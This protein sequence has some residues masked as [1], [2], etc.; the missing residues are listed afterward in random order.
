MQSNNNYKP[1]NQDSSVNLRDA[2][3]FVWR[4]RWIIAASAVLALVVAFAYLRMQ[5][6][7]Y[8]RSTWI[9]LNKND[10]SNIDMNLMSTFSGGRYSKRVDNEATVIKSPSMMCAVV[11]ELG[12]NRRYYHYCM[13]IADRARKGRRLFDVKRVEYYRDN[14]FEMVESADSLF[15]KEF[16]PNSINLTFD[17]VDG[18][19]FQV[20]E[21]IVNGNKIEDF[22]AKE[23]LQYGKEYPIP[24]GH[25]ALNI[26]YPEQM[27]DGDRYVATLSSPW[28]MALS[29]VSKLEITTQPSF[30]RGDNTDVVVAS[31]TDNSQRRADDVLNAL[32]LEVN[33]AGKDYA[34]T[35]AYNTI[36]FLDER[37]ASIAEN[38]NEAEL[39]YQQYQSNNVAIDLASQS[40]LSMSSDMNYQNQLV[41]V[42]TQIKILDMI[43][44]YLHQ[45][46]PGSYKVIP[47][48]IGISDGG[49]NSVISTYNSLVAERNR[50]LANASENNPRVVNLSAQLDESKRGIEVSISNLYKVYR[51][52]ENELSSTLASSKRKMSSLPTQRLQIQQLSRKVSVIEP[53]YMLLQQKREEAQISM[54]SQ[55]ETFRIIEKSYGSSSPVSPL[56]MRVYLLA[57]LI[58]VCVP[59]AFVLLRTTLRSKVETKEDIK[60]ELGLDVLVMI[61]QAKDADNSL[62]FARG[63]DAS[64]ESFRMLRSSLQYMPGSKI[65][66]VTSSIPGEGKSFVS[67]NLAISLAIAGKKVLLIGMDLRKPALH[68]IFGV[69]NPGQHSLVSYMIGKIA[70]PEEAVTHSTEYPGL[71]LVFAGP[72]P[73][74]PSELLNA[75]SQEEFVKALAPAYDYVLIDSAPLL[76]VTDSTIINKMVDET[77]VVVRAGYTDLRLLAELNEALENEHGSIKNPK[78][79][80]NG[81]DYSLVKYHY[82]Y[83][84]SYSYGYGY[85]SSRAKYGYGYGRKYGYGISYRYGGNFDYGYE[86]DEKEEQD[87][88]KIA[89]DKKPGGKTEGG[90]A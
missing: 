87:A 52:R 79:I 84:R 72:V 40:Q 5:T 60:N 50:L 86:S 24:G 49:L 3:D 66:Q 21:L 15:G 74:N 10:G 23:A 76:L 55:V 69:P 33:A 51:I 67:A 90:Q 46:G 43:S 71:D 32:V 26:K 8:Q 1:Q 27:I 29:L 30:I 25:F 64:S 61:P 22:N 12:L 80:L 85:G 53:L 6:P 41:E 75:G 13:P 78:M 89:A 38:L 58:G 20:K 7:Q 81:I 39:D 44:E 77:L 65:F 63:H 14:P 56:P 2:L 18:K 62:I 35:V 31:L 11:E 73:P 34:N 48:N 47:S 59:P 42:T 70:T 9:M 68:K 45:I 36:K 57:F 88:K 16:W 83:G 82:G 28:S 19:T 54:C 17:N 4:L 37:L